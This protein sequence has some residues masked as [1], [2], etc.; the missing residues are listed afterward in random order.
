MTPLILNQV[1]SVAEAVDDI[2]FGTANGPTRFG[3][4]VRASPNEAL[5]L[6]QAFMATLAL[7]ML[8]LAAVVREHARGEERAS[9]L[10]AIVDSS[11]DAILGKTLD[12]TITSWNGAAE[13]LFGYAASEAVGQSIRL[14][15]PP[16]RRD[17]SEAV[18]ARIRAGGSVVHFDTVRR[19]KDGSLVD[20]SL[21]VSPVRDARGR[22]IGASKIARDM[23]ERRRMEVLLRK[24]EVLRYIASLAAAAAHEIN[25]PLAVVVG[26]AQL[27]AAQIERA[28]PGRIDELLAAAWRI[29]DI[30]R[31][32]RHV[33]RL[34]LREDSVNLPAMLDLVRSSRPPL[35]PEARR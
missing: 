35:D 25:N 33:E 16:D 11:D 9:R 31:R 3:P 17:E 27:M 30:V 7:T 21:S 28:E 14:I 18:L 13:R 26:Q 6:L 34:V 32:L 23:S 20:I 22:V 19:R 5:L 24:Q 1:A 4:F 15:I 29:E 8:P 10:A 2:A 12:G